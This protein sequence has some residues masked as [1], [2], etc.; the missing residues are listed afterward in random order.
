MGGIVWPCVGKPMNSASLLAC[1]LGPLC[2]SRRALLSCPPVPFL[3]HA[4]RYLA[5]I[6]CFL[7]CPFIRV[8][9]HG[10]SHGFP[11]KDVGNDSGRLKT[12][13]MTWAESCGPA[14]VKA[15]SGPLPDDFD[16]V[17]RFL[18]ELR[19]PSETRPYRTRSR[20]CGG[21]Q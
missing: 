19:R 16:V 18:P 15:G 12:S 3:C 8:A 9:L 13:G 5:G 14:W 20:V 4:R 6:Q 2:H 10:N 1:P 7:F 21:G 17:V 11:I